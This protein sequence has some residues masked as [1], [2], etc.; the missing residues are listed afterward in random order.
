MIK[1]GNILHEDTNVFLYF[2]KNAGSTYC[3]AT[4]GCP[5]GQ[6]CGSNNYCETGTDFLIFFLFW[7]FMRNLYKWEKLYERLHYK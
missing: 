4:S 2:F 3:T 7:V 1:C 5:F 6:V